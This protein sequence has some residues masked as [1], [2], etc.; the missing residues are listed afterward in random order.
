MKIIIT[1]HTKGLGLHIYNHFVNQG[2][3][4]IGLSRTTGYDLSTDVDKIIDFVKNSNC[5]CFFNNAYVDVQQ[6]VLI[7]E[8]AKHTMVI[9]SGS[10]GSNGYSLY[11]IQNPYF[12]NK[13]KIEVVHIDIKRN[14]PLPMLLLKMGYLE[15]YS[16][17]N[18]IMYEEVLRAIDF[19]FTNT[20]VSLIEFGNINYD[21]NIKPNN[22]QHIDINID[23][24]I[25]NK[26]LENKL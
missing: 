16:E 9:T 8:L 14:N 5:D 11:K 23:D 10:M 19:W 2:H 18:P 4:V 20:R 21:K 1:G 13:Y 25:N 22:P 26:T 15:N 3:E 17:K 24:V 7:K 6:A 12:I